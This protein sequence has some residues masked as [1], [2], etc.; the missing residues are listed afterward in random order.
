[1]ELNSFFTDFLANIRLPEEYAE[2]C[3]K[4]HE[5]LRQ[6]LEEDPKVAPIVV[7]T[8]LQGSYRRGTAVCPNHEQ[9]ADVDVVLVSKLSKEEYT[10]E[11]VFPLFT[12]FLDKYYPGQYRFQGRSIGISLKHVDLDLVIAAAPS[13]SEFGILKSNSVVG[14]ETLEE[15][16]D[17]M[18]DQNWLPAGKRPQDKRYVA[19]GTKGTEEWKSEP[20]Y[21]PDREAKVWERTHPLAQIQWTRDKNARCNGHYVNVVKVIKWWYRTQKAMPK[22]PKGYLIEHLVGVCCPDGIKSVAEGVT[23]TLEAITLMYKNEA[24]Q[25]RTP[26][27]PDHG[28]PEHN[29]FWRVSGFDFAKFYGGVAEAARAARQAYDLTD[30]PQ[31]AAGWKKLLGDSF[32]DPPP[33]NGKGGGKQPD[34]GSF[35][36][37]VA[38]SVIGGGRFA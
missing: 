15:A 3:R 11:K 13:E 28:V 31:S 37:R 5:I 10:P 35:T 36:R 21:I 12:P 32:P 38:P 16:G 4:G 1:M 8:F 9:R 14:Y 34:K 7:S 18:L 25:Y 2:E 22:Y 33:G 20:L 26:Y 17:W 27:L 30:P 23:R 29:V 6:R 24:L 19:K